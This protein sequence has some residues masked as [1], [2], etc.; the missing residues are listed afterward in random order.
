MPRID[1]ALCAAAL[2]FI[3]LFSTTAAAGAATLA[4]L[5]KPDRSFDAGNLHVDVF[6]SG[7]Q[8][9][10]FIPGLASGPWSWSEQIAHFSP[11]YTVY[12]LTLPGFDGHPFG[13]PSDDLLANF[14]TNFWTFIASNSITKPI[15][16]GH[17]LGGT[18]AIDLAEQHPD[19][20]RAAI[21]LDGLPIIPTLAQST[22]AQRDA[23][24]T[25]LTAQIASQTH[26]QVL[27]YEV[28]Y[29]KT[30]G[31][32]DP[33][34]APVLAAECAKS[35]PKAIAAWGAADLRSDLR[36]SLK[37]ATVPILELM[38]YAKP[39]PYTQAQTQQ[40]YEMLL[41]GAPNAKVVAIP[42]ARHFAMIDQPA[43]VDAAITQFLAA[44]PPA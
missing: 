22:T 36:S 39:S 10:I 32:I 23:V 2:S 43:E 33:E 11:S 25:R 26:D 29:M 7:S 17:S 35:D 37:S 18:L 20:L 21:A 12:A 9:M 40:F 19:R 15:V 6:G 31:T 24:A 44:L 14:T 34:L 1:R 30:I 5:P 8:A 4:P 16:I 3:T 28:R 27:A 41:T 13:N 42:G 38:P